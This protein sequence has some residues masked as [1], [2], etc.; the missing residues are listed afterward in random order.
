MDKL[1]NLKFEL[2]EHPHYSPDL[3]TFVPESKESLE[4][5]TSHME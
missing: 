3:D 4:W 2:L 5:K 1:C